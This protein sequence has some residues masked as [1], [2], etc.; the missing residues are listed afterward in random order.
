MEEFMHNHSHHHHHHDAVRQRSKKAMITVLI[1]SA[2]YMGV[3]VFAGLYTGS[4]ALIAD[5]GHMLSDVAALGLALFAN[6]LAMRAPSNE[7]TY[8]Y[9]RSEVLVA[10]FNGALLLALSGYILVESVHRLMA[11]QEILSG[12]ML[13][14]ACGGLV[15]NLISMKLLA[16]SSEHSINAR[17]AYLEV[18][19][20]MLGSAAVIGASILIW[21]TG[22][23]F[24]DPIISGLIGLMIFPRT[25]SLL[26]ECVHILMEGTPARIEL[27]K[28]RAAITRVPGIVDLHDLHVWT[29]T[30]SKDAMSAHV[31]VSDDSDVDKVLSQ[32]TEIA[33]NEFDLHHTT[34]QVERVAC[35]AKGDICPPVH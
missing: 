6:W 2:I 11:P 32:I 19:G 4:L 24:I 25:W 3:E 13:F 35:K 17:A 12:T 15:L 9:Y 27:N 21:L 18:L 31:L 33:R 5:A 23:T 7:K 30:S 22:W 8:G 26:K 1:L 16:P 34:I 14:V 20:D 10:L 29:L 28:L